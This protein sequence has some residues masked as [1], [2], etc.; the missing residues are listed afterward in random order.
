MIKYGQRPCTCEM[1]LDSYRCWPKGTYCCD[2]TEIH[3]SSQCHSCHFIVPVILL[4]NVSN[5]QGAL[6]LKEALSKQIKNRKK[7]TEECCKWKADRCWTQKA[8]LAANQLQPA[9]DSQRSVLS[10]QQPYPWK[11][12]WCLYTHINFRL[13]GWKQTNTEETKPLQS[14][15]WWCT[16]LW[17]WR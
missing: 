16:R 10:R 1:S 4:I 17:E 9:K 13:L 7:K 14:G 3:M 11:L 15:T 6:R 12:Y 8:K 2:L 5:S